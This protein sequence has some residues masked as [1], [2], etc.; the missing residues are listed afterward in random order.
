MSRGKTIS[1]E[2]L[3][4]RLLEA[5][6]EHGPAELSFGKAS[7][8]AGLAPA[9]LVQRF[10]SRVGMVEAVMLHAW[11]RL[12]AETAAADA[13]APADPAG[14]IALLLDLTRPEA[15]ERDFTDGLLLLREDIRNPRLRARGAA[16]G[17]RLAGAV[18]RRLSQDPDRAGRLGWQM[19]GLWQGTLV[20][21]AFRRDAE[22]RAKVRATLEDWARSVGVL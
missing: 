2:Q 19:V 10:G 20:W 12:D 8:A 5:V 17:A 18:G 16:W 14:A 22:P 13:Q 21:W 9:T 7:S 6:L 11:D 4:D 1:D 3:H 15:A